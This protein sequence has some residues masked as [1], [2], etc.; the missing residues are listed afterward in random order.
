MRT[1]FSRTPFTGLSRQLILW[2]LLISL[3]PLIVVSWLSYQ[4][5]WDQLYQD[6]EHALS[7]TAVIQTKRLRDRFGRILI[8]LSEEAERQSNSSFLAALIE[9]QQGSGKAVSEFVKSFRWAMLVE[10]HA[11]DLEG[12]WRAYG[13]YD[14]FLID[15]QG[16]ILFTLAQESDLGWNLFEG[17]LVATRFAR[18]ARQS[19]ES[20]RIVFSDLEHY[21]PSGNA[22]SGF[23]VNPLLDEMGE[24]LGLIGF[25]ISTTSLDA[26]IGLET[27]F[28]E[29]GRRYLVGPDLAL[30]TP[31]VFGDGF[32]V[33]GKSLNTQQARGWHQT[34]IVEN[35]NVDVKDEQVSIYP[36]PLGRP[37]LGMHTSVEFADVKWGYVS[38]IDVDE[39]LYASRQLLILILML[40]GLTSLVVVIIVLPVT[41]SLVR[42]IVDLSDALDK[43][44]EGDLY[45]RLDI[46]A[47]HELGQLV[48]GFNGMIAKLRE[49]AQRVEV[50]QWLQDGSSG[51][52]EQ[53][54]GDPSLE[55]LSRQ[56][57]SF[58]CEY[59]NVAIGAF[60]VVQKDRIRLIGSYA[61]QAGKGLHNEF[62]PGEGLVGQAALDQQIQVLTDIPDDY[63]AIGSGLGETVPKTIVV[64]PLIW[65]NRV[66]ALLEFG[67]ITPFSAQLEQLIEQVGPA[68]AIAVQ[69]ALSR[70]RTQW[71][72]SQTQIQTEELQ[73]REEDLRNTNIQLEQQARDLKHSEEALY[74]SQAELEE[75]NEKLQM[76]QQE[77][78]VANE[79]LARRAEEMAISNKYKSEFLANMSHELRTPLNSLLILSKLLSDNKEGNFSAKQLEYSRTIHDAGSDLLNLINDILDLSKIEAGKM[80]VEVE[81]IRVAEFAAELERRFRHMAENKGLFFEVDASQAPEQLRTDAQKLGQIIKNLLSNAFKFTR[82][83]QVTVRIGQVPAGIRLQTPDLNRDDA[84]AISVTDSGI[85]IPVDKLK[86]VFEVFQQVD[87]SISRKF[88]GTGLG[89]SISRELANLLGGEIQAQSEA[90]KGS[91]FTLTIPRQWRESAMPTMETSVL[92]PIDG[93]QVAPPA[94]NTPMEPVEDAIEE[95][96]AP[97]VAPTVK[98]HDD[99]HQ[100]TP[101]ERSILVIEDDPRFATILVD[102]A[103]ERGF[104]A[105]VAED[106]E[107]GLHFADYYLPS[108]IVLDIGLPGLD[109][110]QVMDRLKENLKTRHIPVHFISASDATLDAMKHGAVGFLTKPVSMQAMD[111]AFGRIE[112]VIDRPV[113]RLLLV[114]DDPAQIESLGELI[115][116]SDVETVTAQTGSEALARLAEAEFDCIVLDLGL[117]DTSGLEL[118]EKLHSQEQTRQTP[119]IVYTGRELDPEERAALDR[120]ARCIIIKDAHS[121]EQLL[122]DTALFLHRV[123]SRLPE[124]RRRMIRMLHDTESLFVGRKVLL[125]DDDMRNVFAISAILQEKSME[126]L[127]AKNGIEALEKLESDSDT[128]I[129]LMDIMMPEMDG[130]EATR[131]I[132]EQERYAGLPV[133]ALTAKAMKGDRAKCIEA[134]ASDYLA[135]P[136]DTEKLLSMMRVWLYR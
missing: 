59:L 9:A 135:K 41:R 132:R 84:L 18:A 43:L 103:R 101:G 104:K 126:V 8:D 64:V 109:G 87:G 4:N 26:I 44:G 20:G 106:G 92:R 22:L 107:T 1:H 45:Q 50:E 124:N 116:N 12:F 14:I 74:A 3:V 79:E 53:I 21:A 48:Q 31:G 112:H 62:R 76:Q 96:A 23:L 32:P 82:E 56:T 27:R 6:T 102:V 88:G 24:K 71:L 78:R 128:A 51:L 111:Q 2:F 119:V 91:T 36:G 58:L 83:G 66:V 123:E 75:H 13:Y 115:G 134:G 129:V 81:L 94:P 46:Q 121:P 38:E 93:R 70:E 72:L 110:W 7:D 39:A 98:T 15:I 30:R 95:K 125:V 77:L 89:L 97:T 100:L 105:L 17:D 99:R 68:I 113:K 11:T 16:N 131:K 34:H 60:Y 29:T 63:L 122:D 67:A 54:Q 49:N 127:V 130:Y 73:A 90:G 52:K 120:H 108:G 37:V 80:Q 47:K 42:P 118:L 117:P 25:Q 85:G 136:V 33:L 114:E 133:I 35:K 40:I 57:I 65:N 10:E 55:D 28:G 61:V 19:L 5:A 86:T 69:T